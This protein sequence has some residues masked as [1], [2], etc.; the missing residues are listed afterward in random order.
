MD[1]KNY[2]T[3]STVKAVIPQYKDLRCYSTL[4][5][6][7]MRSINYWNY[8]SLLKGK[9]NEKYYIDPGDTVIIHLDRDEKAIKKVNR[10]SK[11]EFSYSE[12]NINNSFEIKLCKNEFGLGVLIKSKE[13]PDPNKY[14]KLLNIEKEFINSIIL[15]G[16]VKKDGIVDG[17]FEIVFE[18]SNKISCSM[19]STFDD[20]YSTIIRE[21]ETELNLQSSSRPIKSYK[22]GYVYSKNTLEFVYLGGINLPKSFSEDYLYTGKKVAFDLFI[23][24]DS[25]SEN[26]KTIEDVLM[27]N[28]RRIA[29]FYSSFSGLD[30]E[31]LVSIVK[32]DLILVPVK[33]KISLYEIE[34]ALDETKLDQTTR[35]KILYSRFS[36][37]MDEYSKISTNFHPDTKRDTV[38]L[39][40]NMVYNKLMFDEEDK[41]FVNYPELGNMFTNDIL[42][43][44]VIKAFVCYSL[45]GLRSDYLRHNISKEACKGW[46]NIWKT[47]TV[48]YFW[49]GG[50]NG[51]DD[52]MN[53]FANLVHDIED[54]LNV[55]NLKLMSYGSTNSKV[56]IVNKDGMLDCVSYELTTN[57][58]YEELRTY[59]KDGALGFS[60]L[61]FSKELSKD[62]DNYINDVL[63]FRTAAKNI[64]F[65]LCQVYNSVNDKKVVDDTIKEYIS[66][67]S[68]AKISN[69][70][71]EELEKV[72]IELVNNTLNGMFKYSVMSRENQGSL[73]SPKYYNRI[74]FNQEQL[75]EFAKDN[76][77]LTNSLKT[78]L[79]NSNIYNY[80]F[81][82][83]DIVNEIK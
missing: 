68:A 1:Y 18:K 37:L 74:L 34:K 47:A 24:K 42:A 77:K 41:F 55:M 50:Y 79:M 17:E 5:D 57:D 71:I 32:E 56:D 67:Y 33:G 27:N 22:P 63:G 46:R 82:I 53:Q 81:R 21:L 10:D 69:P 73:K 15:D 48:D 36:N 78:T 4:E 23:R 30:D 44:S 52:Y 51:G 76:G 26:E 28:S 64:G 65:L 72:I 49:T 31:N 3:T 19:I 25:L 35:Y 59:I 75:I 43:N 60:L 8:K 83:K 12:Y 20:Y 62:P 13:L 2:F 40:T 11:K 70:N 29:N 39:V 6:V 38:G 9:D 58:K 80:V 45:D 14:Y 7:P 61:G 54:F 16:L 66:S